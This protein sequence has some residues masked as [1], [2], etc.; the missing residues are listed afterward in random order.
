MTTMATTVS[1]REQELRGRDTERLELPMSF[2]SRPPLNPTGLCMCGCGQPAPLA[3]AT[4]NARGYVNGE[5][6]RFVRNH[7]MRGVKASPETRRRMSEARRGTRTGSD[8][9]RWRGG[10]TFELRRVGIRVGRDHPMADRN[11][12]VLE[13][14]LVMAASLGRYLRSDEIVHH[15]NEDPF[16]N[17]PENLVVVSRSQHLAIHAL[18]K[19][20][21]DQ[22]ESVSIVLG[23]GK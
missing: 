18:I 17:R 23:S 7:H 8:N 11:G 13:H 1:P 12:L 19:S 16:D 10:K 20:G 5:P 21:I 3:V 4:D 9:P 6:L 14:R 2:E 15:I 22:E